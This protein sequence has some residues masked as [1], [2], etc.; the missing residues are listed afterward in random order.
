MTYAA[1]SVALMSVR[2]PVPLQDGNLLAW[3]AAL[4]LS[5]PRMA[6]GIGHS[7]AWLI[8]VLKHAYETT[9]LWFVLSLVVSPL[10][11][12][13]QQAWQT[14]L[15]FSVTV[16]SVSLIAFLVPAYGIFSGLSPDQTGQLPSRAGRYAFDAVSH[17]RT[18]D[19]P[20]LTIHRLAGVVTFP[21]FHTIS[22]LL[23]FQ[24][25]WGVRGL[26]EATGLLA[27]ATIVSTIPMG[28]HYFVDLIAG[29]AL[30]VICWQVMERLLKSNAEQAMLAG[31]RVPEPDALQGR[32]LAGFLKPRAQIAA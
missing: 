12:R 5:A 19:D 28:G 23:T 25:W 18:A 32:M 4:G 2:S 11:G 9:G 24:T 15:L 14:I 1:G 13:S 30:W 27:L 6:I 26:R 17:F 8:E 7:P 16:L 10:V 3:D 22:A 31:T 21:S 20:V 29:A